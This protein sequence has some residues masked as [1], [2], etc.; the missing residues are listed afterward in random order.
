MKDLLTFFARTSEKDWFKYGLASSVFAFLVGLYGFTVSIA[1][2]HI[3]FFVPAPIAAFIV[4]GLMWKWTF[5]KK[6]DYKVGN[7]ISVGLIG[8]P[9][10]HYLTFV[11]MGL[12]RI[13]CYYLTG[14]CTD[15]TGKPDNILYVMSSSIIQSLITI[16]KLGII[17]LPSGILIGLYIMKK[18]KLTNKEIKT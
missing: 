6:D 2:E 17:T 16:Y 10:I 5:K 4:S 9:I 1:A 11:L 3:Y 13:I 7:V 8:I 15:Y 12:G 18:S 14:N